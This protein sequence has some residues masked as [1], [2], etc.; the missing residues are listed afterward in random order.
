MEKWRTYEYEGILIVSIEKL[1]SMDLFFAL[2]MTSRYLDL[3]GEEYIIDYI[4]EFEGDESNDYEFITNLP[5]SK[6]IEINGDC[7]SFREKDGDFIPY[8]I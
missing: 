3:F 7:T 6:F 8:N 4:A 1:E 2:S 5:F